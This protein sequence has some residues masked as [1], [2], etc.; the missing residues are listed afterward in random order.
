[1]ADADL[2]ASTTAS[3]CVEKLFDS[4]PNNNHN[5]N[6]KIISD[7]TKQFNVENHINC[8]TMPT[9]TATL[10]TNVNVSNTIIGTI[11]GEESSRIGATSTVG[12]FNSSITA[13]PTSVTCP[14]SQTLSTLNNINDEIVSTNVL[15]NG[16]TG[17]NQTIV[18]S[19]NNGTNQI[20]NNEINL[21]SS[22]DTTKTTD[23][24]SLSNTAGL[25]NN[26]GSNLTPNILI[27]PHGGGVMSCGFNS[28]PE[29]SSS[30]WSTGDEN[31][32]S[33][34]L[35]GLG[36]F[37]NYSS[38]AQQMYN[39][40]P[41]SIAMAQQQQ[42]QRR[43][44]TASHGSGGFQLSPN[45]AAAIGRNTP[46]LQTQSVQTQQQQQ[47]QHQQQQHQQQQIT[48]QSSGSGGLYNNGYPSWSNPPPPNMSGWQTPAAMG[49]NQVQSPWNRGRS[50]P[51]LN[52]AMVGNNLSCH[53]KPTS[54]NPGPSTSPFSSQQTGIN[55]TMISP[56]KYRRSTS[57]PGKAPMGFHGPLEVSL[58]MD[59]GRDQYMGYQVRKI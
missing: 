33:I 53:R 1:M 8:R 20:D 6:Y 50:V 16:T 14:T 40:G 4:I 23:L 26:G 44:I 15:L 55:Q 34:N 24:S 36:T 49:N 21:T 9:T 12:N 54:P 30:L 42:Q 32:N 2:A 43:A 25:M 22:M 28:S 18:N 13:T 48:K 11:G 3:I 46:L 10:L 41:N 59:D 31:T 57:F 38:T 29:T 39:G 37:A 47:Q 17:G 19:L 58:G 51:N 7:I 5:N 56:S 35:N 52:P 45:S 27:P